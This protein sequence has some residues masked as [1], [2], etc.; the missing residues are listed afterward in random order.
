MEISFSRSI[1]GWDFHFTSRSTTSPGAVPPYWNSRLRPDSAMMSLNFFAILFSLFSL[2]IRQVL[3]IVAPMV[4]S[5][6]N[7]NGRLHAARQRRDDLT[8]RKICLISILV[9]RNVS[10]DGAIL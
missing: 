1:L 6:V 4:Y 2:S 7:T 9:S 5:M 10:P 8:C 3:R